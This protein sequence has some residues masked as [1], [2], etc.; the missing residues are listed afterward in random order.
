[1]IRQQNQT[2]S[3]TGSAHHDHVYTVHSGVLT[4]FYHSHHSG[5]LSSNED[6]SGQIASLQECV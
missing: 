4:V 1:M 3:V 6:V 5:E 2:D